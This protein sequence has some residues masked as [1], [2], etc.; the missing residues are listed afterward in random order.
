[1]RS[2]EGSIL[3]GVL[4]YTSNAAAW[5][6]FQPQTLSSPSTAAPP[7]STGS[8]ICDDSQ[9]CASHPWKPEPTL[10]F[11]APP[12]CK[13]WRG[14]SLYDQSWISNPGFLF[15]SLY[16]ELCTLSFTLRVACFCFYSRNRI[17]KYNVQS[18]KLFLCHIANPP[19]TWITWPV[20]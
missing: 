7:W 19:S 11:F 4:V 15:C 16:F 17:A 10:K 5:F 20:I 18:T 13:N 12:V 1:M 2:F 8:A 3:R 14:A 6:I 9:V